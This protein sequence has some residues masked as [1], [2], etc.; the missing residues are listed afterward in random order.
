[1]QYRYGEVDIFLLN[2]NE[3][4]EVMMQ[5]NMKRKGR[6]RKPRWRAK[7]EEYCEDQVP[8]S[9]E[10][11]RGGSADTVVGTPRASRGAIQRRR[12]VL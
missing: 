3:Q 10:R 11:E 2:T 5:P 6:N 1:M 8:G 4:E 12:T 9:C 7:R